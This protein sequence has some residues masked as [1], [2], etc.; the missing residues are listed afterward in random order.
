MSQLRFLSPPLLL[1]A[2]AAACAPTSNPPGGD[3]ASP[4]GE[5]DQPH[6]VLRRV[7]RSTS[8]AVTGND[9]RVLMV[10]PQASTV[11]LFDTTTNELIV[12]LATG[13]EPSSVVIH[14]DDTAAFVANTAD[15]TVVRID[16]IDGPSPA[17]SATLAVGSEPTGLA[18]SPSG[19]RLY[20]AEHAEG[21]VA[22]VDTRT[23]SELAAI[24]PPRSPRGLAVT[25]DGDQDDDDELILVPEFFGEP[26]AEEGTDASRRGRIR[27]YAASD[28]SAGEPILFEP[29]DSGFAPS[30]AP[31]GAPTVMTSPNQLWTVEVVDGKVYVPA[32]AASPDRPANFQ[33]NVFPTVLVGDL[34][35]RTEVRSALGTTNLARLVR[36]QIAAPVNPGDPP[37]FFLADPVDVAFVN[38]EVGY[39]LS[40]GADVMQRIVY[41]ESGPVLGGTPFNKQIDLNVTPEGSPGPCQNPT[42]MAL[43]HNGGRAWVNCWGTRRLGVIDFSTQKLTRT[44]TSSEISA[45]DRPAQLGLHFFFTGRGRWSANAWSSCGS[46]HPDGRS[47]NVTW[48]FAAGPRQSTAL[49]GSYSR[50]TEVKRRALNWTGIFDEMA[51]FERNTRDVQGGKG[52]I[53]RPDPANAGAACGNLAQEVQVALSAD[54]LGRSVKLDQDAAGTCTKDW[55]SIDAYVKQMVRPPGAL[56]KLDAASVARGAAL[57][58]E[59]TATAANAGCVRC[60]GGAGWTVSR[61]HFTPSTADP[62]PLT[63]VRFQA[64]SSWAPSNT[65]GG[66]NFQQLQIAPQPASSLFS[67]PEAT[68]PQNPRQIACVLRNVATFGSD[69]LETRVVRRSDGTLNLTARAQGRLGFNVPSLYGM[70]LGAPFFHHGKAPTLE[71]LLDD[72]AWETHATAGNPNWLLQGSTAEIAQRKQDLIH[73]VLSID[74]ATPEQSIPAGFDGCP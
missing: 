68:E 26:I 4:P 52:A 43:A 16:G 46:C 63:T 30:T 24:T 54:G 67:G 57:F 53:T 12:E 70:A 7:S 8:I 15:G 6:A 60:H 25:N 49:D 71:A 35:A 66:W 17:V 21:R 41:R 65:T 19:A 11:S 33:T 13:G 18:L 5:P 36:D 50:G 37:R 61:V 44:V 47:D 39:V 3:D 55:D 10:N 58:G 14:P 9:T 1:L 20:V 34:A 45:A 62:S 2:A 64:P 69:A 42:G 72:P 27:I 22:V 74:A 48:S 59:P 28:L 29:F 51:D 23:M 32:I 40:R 38:K 73:F 31:A 56:R